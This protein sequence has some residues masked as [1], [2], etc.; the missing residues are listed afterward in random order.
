MQVAGYFDGAMGTG[1][2]GRQLAA[3]LR[4]QGIPIRPITLRPDGA[5]E[6]YELGR[7]FHATPAEPS[8]GDADLE[9]FNLLCANAEMVP[10]VAGL[11]GED[12]FAGRYTI[13][14]WAWEVSAFPDRYAP[15]FDSLDEVWVGS[16]HVHDAVAARSPVP[17]L[18]IPQPV[19]LAPGAEHATAP[20]DLPGG[21]RFLFAFD[22]LS[23]FERKNP[24]ATIAAFARAFEPGA[25]ATLVV[26]SLNPE[27][28]PAAHA[29]LRAAAAEHPDIQVIEERL[30]RAERDGLMAAADC[31]VSLHRAEGFGYTLAESMWLG[32][33]VIATGYSG[34]VDFMSPENSYLVDHRLVPIG[35]GNDPYPPEGVWAE[36]DVDHAA[37]LMREVFEGREAA[38]ERGRRAAA[39]IRASHGPEAA[40]RVMAE[41]LGE[42]EASGA[43][44]ASSRLPRLATGRAGELIRSGP[45]PP[46]R[47]RFGAPQLAARKGLLRVLKPVTVHQRQVGG[48]LLGAIE[49]LDAKVQSLSLA[50]REALRHIDRL[51]AELRALRAPGENGRE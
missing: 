41:R 17:V 40:G 45:V 39:E 48:E 25:G 27:H 35:A 19:S 2:H 34:N 51:E 12:F 30:S 11:L 42:L 16:R 20:A 18:A 28:D 1:E 43:P 10:A 21:F 4:T 38:A 23:V 33:P 37:R 22:Y 9:Q 5:P 49:A 3:S 14:F 7:D 32:K 36:P 50:H 29:R 31:Y 15:A 46:G 8:P 24:L 47:P 26:K 6:D 13:G 44:R